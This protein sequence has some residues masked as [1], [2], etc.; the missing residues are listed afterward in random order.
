MSWFGL[1]VRRFAAL[2]LVCTACACTPLFENHGYAPEDRDLEA[3]VV[4]QTTREE[5][6]DLI[7]RPASSGVLSASGWYYVQSRWRTYAFKAPVEI[8]RQVIAISFSD[9]GTVSNV[10]RFGLQDGQVVALSR[11]ITESN[12]KGISLIRQLLSNVGRISADQL[13]N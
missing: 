12:I 2:V 10:E 7:G 9:S 4:G 3:V 8:D 1:Q 13:T 11:R 6:P 5:L